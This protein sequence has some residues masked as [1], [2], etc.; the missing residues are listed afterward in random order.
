MTKRESEALSIINELRK[1]LD[2]FDELKKLIS[3]KHS[4]L[5]DER[6]LA[7]DLFINLRENLDVAVRSKKPK[8]RIGPPCELDI[9]YFY[10]AVNEA[11][12]RLT[13]KPNENPISSN[14]HTTLTS[15]QIDIKYMLS[16]IERQFP[17]LSPTGKPEPRES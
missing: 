6:S 8:D 3:N 17:D 5:P 2:I 10:W 1:F 15:S 16:E 13:I 7:K 12:V 11:R 4:L 14:W 9:Q